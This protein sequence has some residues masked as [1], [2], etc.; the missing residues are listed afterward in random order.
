MP[1]WWAQRSAPKVASPLGTPGY[2]RWK[3]NWLALMAVI[4]A[5]S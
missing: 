1:V 3:V 5:H 2:A 4:C